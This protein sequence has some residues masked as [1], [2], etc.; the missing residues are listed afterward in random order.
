[1]EKNIEYYM[2]L[3]YK[4]IIE[5]SSEGGYVGYIPDLK[6]CITQAETKTELLDMLEDA[7]KGWI[8]TALEAGIDILEPVHDADFSGKFNLRLP[9][10]LH[11]KL[12]ACA[13]DEG[14]SLNQ[15]AMC[16][17]ASGLH[18]PLAK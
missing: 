17:I 10:S 15:M 8:E 5:A 16:L 9:K 12:A 2:K 4:E 11:R 18:I 14:V 1:M 3:P 7:K 13:K 6:G